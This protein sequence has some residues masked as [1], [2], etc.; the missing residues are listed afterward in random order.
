MNKTKMK[1]KHLCIL[2]AAPGSSL[3]VHW[4]ITVCW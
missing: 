1:Y 2:G 4:H 3:S